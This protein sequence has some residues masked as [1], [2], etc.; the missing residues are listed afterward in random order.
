MIIIRKIFLSLIIALFVSTIGC[1]HPVVL[2][3]II[4]T[5]NAKKKEAPPKLT[6]TTTSLPYAVNN[7]GYNQTFTANN[8]TYPYSWS[9]ATG[10]LP[11]NIQLDSVSGVLS[12]TPEDTTGTYIFTVS[13]QDSTFPAKTDTKEFTLLLYDPLQIT[14]P[15]GLPDTVN[16]ILYSQTF[17]ATGGTGYNT[18]SISSGS[19][20]SGISFNAEHAEISG[21]P[22][23]TTG[24]Y[25]F[26]LEVHDNAVP[27]QSAVLPLSLN[28]YD[29]LI[30][31]LSS[32]SYAVN[33][34]SYEQQLTYSGGTGNITWCGG[35][36]LPFGLSIDSTGLISGI[37]SDTVG[38]YRF[39]V[40]AQDDGNPQQT[41]TLNTIIELYEPLLI[42]DISPL[43]RAVE[44]VH[45]S[46][47]FTATGGSGSRS[48]TWLN[49]F[50]DIP[51]WLTLTQAGQLFGTPPI[52]SADESPYTF[53]IQVE[54]SAYPPQIVEVDFS[55]PVVRELYFEDAF[56]DSSKIDET[57]S[58]NTLVT[59]GAVQLNSSYGSQAPDTFWSPPDMSPAHA[60]GNTTL[61]AQTFTITNAGRLTAASALHYRQEVDTEL[62]LEVRNV[63]DRG[64]PGEEIYTSANIVSPRRVWGWHTVTFP[65]PVEVVERQN[66]ALVIRGTGTTSSQRCTSDRDNPYR[67]GRAFESINSGSSW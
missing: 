28:L 24:T 60:F 31:N 22:D 6:I 51:A 11:D 64:T 45:Y 12:G 47:T 13:V 56:D 65:E 33:T 27:L 1:G 16:S 57:T 40:Q 8:G 62:I 50:G 46:Y 5:S 67:G 30:I 35:V 26:T 9:I 32:L 23:A 3:A 4:S 48:C 39:E 38:V 21:T 63:T 37:P 52:G 2:A 10:A 7:T 53:T 59:A 49:P 25:S 34:K 20:P 18:W 42:A 66:L 43:E 29:K 54:D 55:L 41:S 58:I 19:L 17:T 15:D 14:H 44:E 61:L 36:N